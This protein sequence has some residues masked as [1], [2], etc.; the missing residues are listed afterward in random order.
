[1]TE[2]LPTDTLRG[3]ALKRRGNVR[4]HVVSTWNPHGVFVVYTISLLRKK[5]L[6]KTLIATLEPNY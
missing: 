1:M 2:S 4:F 6:L 3:S 5:K